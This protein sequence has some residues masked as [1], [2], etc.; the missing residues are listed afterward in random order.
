M[1]LDST[2]AKLMARNAGIDTVLPQ[3]MQAVNKQTSL[4]VGNSI[5]RTMTADSAFAKL[6]A[7]NAIDSPTL[8]RA[9]SKQSGIGVGISIAKTMGA[10]S[11]FA[12]L[13]ARNAGIDTAFA[14]LVAGNAID[15]P[16]LMRAVSK[17][18]DFGVG[19]S[20]AKAMTPNSEFAN[21]MARNLGID[22][23]LSQMRARQQT[24]W[25]RCRP[26]HREDHRRRLHLREADGPQRWDRHRAA[27]NDASRQQTD[28]PRRRQLHRQD[29]DPRLRTRQAQGGNPRTAGTGNS[30]G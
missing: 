16:T 26:I 13:M 23:V 22:T 28:Q 20:I 24:V 2:F 7:G 5:A 8:M 14:K 3:M 18:T 27:A 4:G 9:V 10:D 17:Q 25:H 19:L 12:K 11:T 1:S 15:S 21:L 29:H 30:R 6:V